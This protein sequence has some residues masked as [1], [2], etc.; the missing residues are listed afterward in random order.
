MH[1]M[2]FHGSPKK[3]IVI[4]SCVIVVFLL[5]HIYILSPLL[6]GKDELV[7]SELFTSFLGKGVGVATNKSS[8][9]TYIP[10]QL[11]PLRELSNCF[12]MFRV[13]VINVVR[14]ICEAKHW[15]W[16]VM[17][18]D[19]YIMQTLGKLISARDTLFIVHDSSSAFKI[20]FFKNITRS[21]CVLISSISKAYTVTGTKQSQLV[22]SRKLTESFGC[23]LN[24]LKIFPK[25]F[26]ASEVK[27]CSDFHF[28]I[29]KRP[30]SS[31]IVKPYGGIV[32]KG[33]KIYQHVPALLERF[34]ECGR[35]QH[36]NHYVIQEYLPN[37]LL[38]NGRKFDIRAFVLI[39]RTDPYFLYYHPGYLRV[40]VNRLS[41]A[42]G[43]EVHLT[44]T[45]I[46]EQIEGFTPEDHYWTFDRFQ[47]YISNISSN[48]DQFVKTILE[49]IIKQTGLFLLQAGWQHL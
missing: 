23:T 7:P 20:D 4:L 13:T 28:Y 30:D 1:L 45:H 9:C 10:A 38:L 44:N 17:T 24:Q 43:R 22:Y 8:I 19:S 39:A 18:N 40:A 3:L 27:D 32:G 46:Q 26:L 34:K 37:L 33:I 11:L 16:K 41:E 21:K 25:S 12:Y 2:E 49:P 15:K 14:L 35:K 36:T 5:F 48:N 29:A 31:W 6:V 42:D 47:K